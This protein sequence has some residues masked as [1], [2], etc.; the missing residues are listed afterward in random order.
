M[1]SFGLCNLTCIEL[2]GLIILSTNERGRA[3]GPVLSHVDDILSVAAL[4]MVKSL[5]LAL[6]GVWECADMGLAGPDMDAAVNTCG[7]QYWVCGRIVLHQR[8]FA[9]NVIQT[10]GLEECLA[11]SSSGH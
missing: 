8:H 4:M 11:N 1:N 5:S 3:H 7:H 10:W 6:K 9:V 2:S